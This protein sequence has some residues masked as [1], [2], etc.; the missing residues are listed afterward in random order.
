MN[1]TRLTETDIL[2]ATTA[3]T[4][5]M[6]KG[7]ASDLR[8]SL[9]SIFLSG[10][11]SVVVV[12]MGGN[13]ESVLKALMD[14][15][16]KQ[17]V[18]CSVRIITS[19]NFSRGHLWNWG[20]SR[21]RS[22]YLLF[23]DADIVCTPRMMSA[24]AKPLVERKSSLA[25]GSTFYMDQRSSARLRADDSFVPTIKT[26]DCDDTIPGSSMPIG[27]PD[28]VL[29][30]DRYSFYSCGGF[31]G[32]LYD[33]TV[34]GLD[35]VE[36]WKRQGRPTVLVSEPVFHLSHS[37]RPYTVSQKRLSTIPAGD[38]SFSTAS[39]KEKAEQVVIV[40][41]K[42]VKGNADNAVKTPV[43]HSVRKDGKSIVI[44][45]ESLS[46]GG[47]ERMT[48]DIANALADND[49][50]GVTVVLSL[51]DTGIFRS[52]LSRNVRVVV[53]PDI[54][55]TIEIIKAEN[56]FAVLANN[57]RM[58]MFHAT[59][60]K[61]ET[62]VPYLAT[63]I[64]GYSE[65]SLNLLP[66]EAEGVVDEVITISAHAKSGLLKM[67]PYWQGKIAVIENYTDTEKFIPGK[68]PVSILDKFGWKH[69]DRVFGYMGRISGE[70]SLITMIDIFSRAIESVPNSRLLIV[71]GV[72]ESVEAFRDYYRGQLDT[73]TQYIAQKGLQ[74]RVGITGI[75]ADPWNYLP[76]IDLFIMT[77]TMEGTPLALLEAL[78][79]GIPAVCT[80]VG[81]IPHI[82]MNGFG[83]TS[84]PSDGR[85]MSASDRDGFAEAMTRVMLDPE[86]S[87]MGRR[88]RQYIES[89]HSI[90][91]FRNDF[92]RHY[93]S[94]WDGFNSSVEKAIG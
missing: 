21:V 84:G 70:K 11:H 36:R 75:V 76:A 35:L 2:S 40:K 4:C 64:H 32:E 14:M 18:Y 79:C 30:C 43:L 6:D 69:D 82:L 29:L 5:V 9:R 27:G 62:A 7:A 83:E 77:S 78:A 58:A 56:P 60:I 39:I 1:R 22:D 12:D 17:A 13:S 63:L 23:M 88:A 47:A 41:R 26:V 50:F 46:I 24:L 59:R 16:W 15:P 33:H 92:V 68:R 54:D 73:L 80:P 89:N 34:E 20:A 28:A 51:S 8:K 55:K 3:I 57:S 90:A 52:N 19:D 67:R 85:E 74:N 38:L 66:K 91:R 72:D 81:T 93:E 87:E 53:A 71:G 61:K 31:D 86:R 44:L 48:V 94:V 10:V 42:V 65:W 25:I 49:R 37:P 45:S